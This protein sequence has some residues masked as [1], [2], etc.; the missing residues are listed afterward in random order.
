MLYPLSY[1]GVDLGRDPA[2]SLADKGYALATFA[3]TQVRG[4]LAWHVST[5]GPP[6]PGRAYGG[7]CPHPGRVE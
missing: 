4:V 1:E 3:F 7:P 5:A 6:A 2:T